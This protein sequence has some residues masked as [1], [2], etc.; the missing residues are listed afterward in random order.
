SARSIFRRSTATLSSRRSARSCW[1]SDSDG[2]VGSFD[3]TA[4]PGLELAK[5]EVLHLPAQEASLHL[6]TPDAFCPFVGKPVELS[7]IDEEA[8]G[9]LLSFLLDHVLVAR[10]GAT[11]DLHLLEPAD[12]AGQHV[13]GIAHALNAN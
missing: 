1:T 5:P 3:I 11:R 4:E 12:L 10:H 6:Q 8:Q 2:L 7:G 9:E 13:D